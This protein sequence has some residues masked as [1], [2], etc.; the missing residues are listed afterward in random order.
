MLFCLTLQ[1]FCIN[2][3]G[4]YVDPSEKSRTHTNKSDMKYCALFG[5]PLFLKCKFSPSADSKPV[6][7]IIGIHALCFWSKLNRFTLSNIC[8]YSGMS[9]S[10]MRNIRIIIMNRPFFTSSILWPGHKQTNKIDKPSQRIW[11]SSRGTTT[12]T[13]TK[14]CVQSADALGRFCRT[15]T[16]GHIIYLNHM[17][18]NTKWITASQNCQQLFGWYEI[19]SMRE[20]KR[21][22]QLLWLLS[23]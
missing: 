18:L 4:I 13:T 8:I 5:V 1:C 9:E 16:Y 15:T 20:K 14:K 21:N 23:S 11:N 19:K 17:L 2:L 10:R 22:N 12:A 6:K 3:H 7:T